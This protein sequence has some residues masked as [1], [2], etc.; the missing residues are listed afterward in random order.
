ME[1]CKFKGSNCI[2]G[3]FLE[4]RK[5][6]NMLLSI[7]NIFG[8]SPIEPLLKHME[9]VER[10]FSGL[11]KAIAAMDQK[12]F[13]QV[14]KE[15]T[16]VS[17]LEHKAD[18]VKNDI[19]NHLPKGL[20][21]SFDRGSFLEI[22]ALQDGL[23]DTCEDIAVLLTLRDLTFEPF[24]EGLFKE[25]LEN[26]LQAFQLTRDIIAEMKCLVESSFGGDE[27]EEVKKLIHEVAF[28][29]H[30]GDLIQRKLLKQL[31]QEDNALSPQLFD[32][33]QKIIGKVGS[34]A[35]VCEKLGN[36]VRM[37]LDNK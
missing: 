29:E 6:L 15:A 32:L 17:R 36:R 31:Y 20:F 10:C 37:I 8:R 28:L 9:I 26:S 4:T 3:E 12:D 14:E 34:V 18:M 16:E 11:K 19:R 21:L 33:W 30:K 24:M 35:D 27:A 25:L 5:G 13:I 2:V 1:T 23:A 7:G 22:L